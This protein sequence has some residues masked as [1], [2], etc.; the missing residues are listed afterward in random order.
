VAE[1]VSGVCRWKLGTQIYR[2]SFT[3]IGGNQN[4]VVPAFDEAVGD[5]C[6]GG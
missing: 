5:V 2:Y 3:S 6:E 4:E 1:R